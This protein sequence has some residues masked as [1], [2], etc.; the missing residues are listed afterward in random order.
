MKYGQKYKKKYDKIMFDLK[1]AGISN[2]IICDSIGIGIRTFYTWISKYKSFRELYNEAANAKVN[3]KRALIKRSTGYNYTERKYVDG[4]LK[5][6][7]DKHQAADISA[8]K[9]LLRNISDFDKEL[10][11]NIK[12]DMQRLDNE[13]FEKW[14]DKNE[15]EVYE[16]LRKIYEKENGNN[17]K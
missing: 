2:K 12:I 1:L 5:E 17:T 4:V 9:Y 3:A 13:K 15:L 16:K 8:I 6:K 11:H 7:L 10:E 14:L